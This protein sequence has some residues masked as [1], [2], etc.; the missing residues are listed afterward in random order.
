MRQEQERQNQQG[1]GADAQPS[2]LKYVPP[3]HEGLLLNDV[4]RVMKNFKTHRSA[5][6]F[7]RGFI[8]SVLKEEEPRNKRRG[9]E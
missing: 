6:D 2:T 8:N 1:I 4:Q 9:R 5:F 7:D 3:K